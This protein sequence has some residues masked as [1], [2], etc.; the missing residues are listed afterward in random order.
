MGFVM[1]KRFVG[2]TPSIVDYV[3]NNWNMINAKRSLFQIDEEEWLIDNIQ[4][5]WAGPI[6]SILYFE[7]ECDFILYKLSWCYD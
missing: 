4:G 2:L 5:N 6:N 3:I 7:D 1:G